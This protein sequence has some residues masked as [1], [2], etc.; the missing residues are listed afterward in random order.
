MATAPTDLELLTQL[1]AVLPD[2]GPFLYVPDGWGLR[3]MRAREE[4]RRGV[5][6]ASAAII[7]D[8]I[9]AQGQGASV[10]RVTSMPSLIQTDIQQKWGNGGSGFLSHEYATKTGTWTAGDNTFAGCGVLAT[11]TSTMIWTGIEGTQVRIFHRNANITGAFRWRIDGGSFTTV[12]PPTDFGQEPGN[13]NI[14]GLADGSHTVEVQWVS[15]NVIIHGVKGIRST[16]V[17]LDRIGQSGRAAS[18]YAAMLLEHLPGTG[19]TNNGTAL[20]SAGAGCF[21]P[22][23][24]G[25][26]IVGAG[27]PRDATISA[28]ASATSATLS[29][30][31]TATGTIAADLYFNP[32]SA[33]GCPTTTH[34]PAFATGLGR[35]D[36]VIVMLGA[37]DPA[38]T[39]YNAATWLEGASSWITQYTSNTF[40]TYNY[41]PDFVFVT[42]HFGNWFDTRGI[43]AQIAAGIPELAQGVGGAWI[44][45]WGIGGRNFKF[46]ND[47]GYFADAIHPTDLAHRL[48]AQKVLSLIP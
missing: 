29:V 28:V 24:V 45:V 41:T 32:P 17:I 19:T 47:L 42:E 36:L 21:R 44:D 9:G 3:M 22:Y 33:A 43:K 48:Y 38:S 18:H 26:Y 46:W 27:I 10:Q 39:D 4:A 11:A 14:T 37:N 31:A 30:N 7:S 40:S 16:G 25:K 20:T 23:M 5:R 34:D 13:V 15:G 35:H 1:T 6:L 12:T 2:S 8:S